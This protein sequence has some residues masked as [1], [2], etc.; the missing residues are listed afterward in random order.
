MAVLPEV[1]LFRSDDLAEVLSAIDDV[2]VPYAG[3]TELVPAMRLGVRRPEVLVDL[4]RVDAL[5]GISVDTQAQ[6]VRI[7]AATTHHTI[8]GSPEVREHVPTLASAASHVGNAR[9]RNS[10]TLGGNLCFA[11]PR[12][13][14]SV[15]LTAL[16]AQVELATAV[17]KTSIPIAELILGAFETCLTPDQLMIAVTVPFEPAG[18]SYWKLQSYERPTVGIATLPVDDGLMI[19]VGAATERP[20]R[21]TIAM[22]DLAGLE[23]FL[24]GLDLSDDLAG[25]PEY[26]RSVLRKRLRGAVQGTQ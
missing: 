26:K 8:A 20:E 7:G 3:A 15:V 9:V 23:T 14:L 11:E 16:G 22:G 24:D 6:T 2:N 12:S 19:V 21:A 13:D 17:E 10:G 25:T 5:R 4:K 18:F 1:G